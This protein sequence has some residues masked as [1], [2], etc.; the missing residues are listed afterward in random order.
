MPPEDHGNLRWRGLLVW[1]EGRGTTISSRAL[2]PETSMSMP[3]ICDSRYLRMPVV[4][5][6][7][8][9]C[10]CRNTPGED[11]WRGR[12]AEEQQSAAK[13]PLLPETPSC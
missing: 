10:T 3:C 11:Y 4:E 2:L 7:N 8:L 1:Q 12:K 6:G 13:P 5:H 9:R